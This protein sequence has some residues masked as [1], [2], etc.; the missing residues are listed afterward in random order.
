MITIL[1]ASSYCN[2]PSS[3]FLSYSPISSILLSSAPLPSFLSLL[4]S[5]L[6]LSSLSSPPLSRFP[7]FLPSLLSSPLLPSTLFFFPHFSYLPSLL[8]SS[9][10]SPLFSYSHHPSPFPR[11]FSPP[12]SS[13]F[14]TFPRFFISSCLFSSPLL[15][16]PFHFFLNLSSFSHSSSLFSFPHHTSPPFISPLLP[17]QRTSFR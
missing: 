7:T 16:L 13:L 9:S 2:T 11:L 6:F 14:L 10:P 12:P 3:P 4:F 17:S 1:Q 15:S 8:L 5:P